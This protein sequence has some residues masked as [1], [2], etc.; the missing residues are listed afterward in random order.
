M[1]NHS[2]E[3]LKA[4]L[5]SADTEEWIDLMF[6]R[7][8]GY[9]WALLFRRLNVKP[10]TV[11]IASIILGV[12]AGVLFYFDNLTINIVG[13][14]LLVWANMYD[15]ADGQ[16]ARMTGQTSEIGR[17]LDGLSGDFWF[18]TIYFVICFRLNAEWGWVIWAL[19]ILAGLSHRMQAAMSDYY[20]NI[21]LFFLKGKAGSELDNAAKQQE[22]YRSLPW[23]GNVVQKL[24]LRGY[25]SYTKTQERFSPAFQ[26]FFKTLHAKYGE[27]CPTEIRDEFL[28]L[29]RPLMKY[30]NILTFNTRIIVLFISLFIDEPW[31]YFVFDITVLNLLLVYMIGRHERICRHFIPK[32]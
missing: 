8:V 14:C 13:M 30:T 16:L 12:A 21:H 23:R 7:P 1:S 18:N 17:I 24:F 26:R 9:R 11:T 25:I 10:N 20:R 19:A 29:S 3:E 2:K 6:Y 4:T 28:E 5:K 15:S 27:A 32:I 22:L 31:L